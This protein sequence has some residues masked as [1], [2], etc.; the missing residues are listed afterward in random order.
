VEGGKIKMSENPNNKLIELTNRNSKIIELREKHWSY[1][2]IMDEVGCT[3]GVVIAVLRKM[4]EGLKTKRQKEDPFIYVLSQSKS[5]GMSGGRLSQICD[6]I[7]IE[8]VK[9]VWNNKPEGMNFAESIGVIVKDSYL[10]DIWA[11]KMVD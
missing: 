10:Y 9:W 2:M 8:A 7:G 11:R 6:V 5:V 3:K 4:R 1:G